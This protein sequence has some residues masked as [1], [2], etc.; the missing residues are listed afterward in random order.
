MNVHLRAQGK[1]YKKYIRP[2]TISGTL[3]KKGGTI[4][5]N[6]ASEQLNETYNHMQINDELLQAINE[7]SES[8]YEAIEIVLSS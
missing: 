6:P 4:L 2:K 3:K 5:I 8:E 7:A 1:P